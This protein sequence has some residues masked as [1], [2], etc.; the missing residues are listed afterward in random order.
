VFATGKPID[1]FRDAGDLLVNAVSHGAPDLA[2]KELEVGRF[3]ARDVARRRAAAG[4]VFV[5]EPEIVPIHAP[6]ERESRANVAD[7]VELEHRPV[8]RLADGTPGFDQRSVDVEE[9]DAHQFSLSHATRAAKGL[10]YNA[11]NRDASSFRRKGGCVSKTIG[12][13]V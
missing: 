9:D 10:K 2:R 4:G 6:G 3:D 11:C 7:S 8:Q 13:L 12:V 5:S 1:Q